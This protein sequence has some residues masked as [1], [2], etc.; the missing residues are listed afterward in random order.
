MVSMGYSSAFSNRGRHLCMNQLYCT[1]GV[2]KPTVLDAFVN[3][4]SQVDKLNSMRIL[5]LQDAADEQP[6]QSAAG[7]RC[8]YSYTYPQGIETTDG[9]PDAL[10]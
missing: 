6:S 2:E 8:V 9:L 4:Q 10:T 7:I 5:T 3:V 1:R